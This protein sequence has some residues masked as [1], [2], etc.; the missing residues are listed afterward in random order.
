[1]PPPTLRRFALLCGPGLSPLRAKAAE[2][3]T[4]PPEDGKLTVDT[5]REK[6]AKVVKEK[7]LDVAKNMLKA[8]GAASVTA[9]TPDKFQLVFDTCGELLGE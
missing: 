4:T 5:V 8:Y 2:V 6:V 1:M 3:A 7:G 9:L